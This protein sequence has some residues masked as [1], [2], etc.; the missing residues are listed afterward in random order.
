MARY[1]HGR[2]DFFLHAAIVTL[3]AATSSLWLARS[4]V[5]QI[6]QAFQRPRLDPRRFVTPRRAGPTPRFEKVE[7]DQ[8][9]GDSPEA[10]LEEPPSV[11]VSAPTVAPEPPPPPPPAPEEAETAASESEQQPEAPAAAEPEPTPAPAPAPAPPPSVAA[12]VISTAYLR[13]SPSTSALIT[14]SLA[15]GTSVSVVGCSAAC[16]WL[17]VQTPDGS[18]AWSSA[19]WFAVQG[20]LA[21]VSNR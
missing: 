21:G 16:S 9:F 12:R 4:E 10:E 19:N 6:E 11:A 13:T 20:N 5:E 2:R 14:R 3:A 8:N 7:S 15:P 1:R 17:L 18:Q